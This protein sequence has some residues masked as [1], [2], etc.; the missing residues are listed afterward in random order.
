MSVD[1]IRFRRSTAALLIAFSV[2][3][4]MCCA[5]SDSV[6]PVV[7]KDSAIPDVSRPVAAEPTDVASNGCAETDTK[8]RVIYRRVKICG[9]C[10]TWCCDD[11]CRKLMPCPPPCPACGCVD[12]YC[13]KA[14][15][16][17]PPRSCGCVDDYCRKPLPGCPRNCEPWYN[18]IPTNP[19]V[20]A[21]SAC[22]LAP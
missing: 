12:D 5:A 8:T 17:P 14:L 10:D 18:C 7:K 16:C 11:Y 6:P 22:H 3:P 21:R 4:A 9:V 20:D 2:M 13:R 1:Q 15:P 19:V